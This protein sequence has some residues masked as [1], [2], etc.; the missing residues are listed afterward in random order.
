MSEKE[1]ARPSESTSEAGARSDQDRASAR[2]KVQAPAA[3]A[4]QMED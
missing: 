3:V 1:A 4:I 2:T